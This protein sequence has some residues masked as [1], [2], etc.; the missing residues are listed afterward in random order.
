MTPIITV[1]KGS[2]K[3]TISRKSKSDKYVMFEEGYVT[4]K[5]KKEMLQVISD[6][7]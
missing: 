4:I 1:E 7:L 6:M 3:F 5:S 2:R